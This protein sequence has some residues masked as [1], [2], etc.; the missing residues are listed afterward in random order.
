MYVKKVLLAV[1]PRRLEFEGLPVDGYDQGGM[2][3]PFLLP[4]FT[5]VRRYTHYM[6][7][8]ACN[9][10]IYGLAVSHAKRW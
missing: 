2:P 8:L 5:E 9:A 10:C 1:A 6:R 4:S 3:Q 7:S